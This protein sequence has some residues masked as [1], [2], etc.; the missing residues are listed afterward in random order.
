MSE[1]YSKAVLITGCSSGI[2]RA[3][4]VRLAEAGYVVFASVRKEHDAQ[5]LRNLGQPSLFSICPLDLTRAEQ[6][7][8]AKAA[9][10]GE[11]RRRGM[12]GLFALINNAGAGTPAP[13]EMMNLE[14]LRTELGTRVV[15]S[16]AMVQAFLPLIREAEGRLVW[17]VTPAIIPTPYVAS[18]HSSDFAINCI[19]R[20]LE[21]ELKPWRVPNVMIRCGGIKTPAGLRTTSDVEANLRKAPPEQSRLYEERFQAWAKDMAEFDKKRT[22]PEAVAEVVL[23]ALRAEK[24]KRRYSIGHMAWAAAFLEALPQRVADT[25][26]KA[27]F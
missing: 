23:R 6:I 13:V 3:V 19:A 9:V 18:I 14:E 11:L 7:A 21:I 2:G 10:L 15:G 26:L 22:E 20:T 16:V 24:P 17:I 27:R 8:S 25:V 5:E 12:R 4:A 1:Q